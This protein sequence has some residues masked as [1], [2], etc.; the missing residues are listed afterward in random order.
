MRKR[1][2][3]K[4]RNNLLLNVLL[5]VFAAMFVFALVK[6]ILILKDYRE[7]ENIYNNIRGSYTAEEESIVHT[8]VER[9]KKTET[10]Q[11]PVVTDRESGSGQ[12]SAGSSDPGTEQKSEQNN[13]Q[14]DEADYTAYEH[15]QQIRILHT[16]FDY[17]ITPVIRFNLDAL[18]AVNPEVCGWIQIDGTHVDYPIVQGQDNSKYL[19]IAANGESNNAGSIFADYRIP[20]LYDAKNL[21]IY[22][23]NQRNSQMFHDLLFYQEDGYIDEHPYI[24]IT[25]TDGNVYQY[26]IYSA[27]Y[28]TDTYTYKY[29]FSN[30]EVYRRYLEYTRES[31]IFDL[32]VTPTTDQRII[33]L[34][35]CTNESDDRR[36]VV[37]AVLASVRKGR[38]QQ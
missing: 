25:G 8:A 13:T 18:K 5:I 17:I 15:E 24:R 1:G 11:D 26:R 28:M 30:D 16:T 21:I 20:D 38:A 22:G 31:S 4:K 27:Y 37:H 33:T 19:R 3:K 9:T 7:G 12:E 6:L 32:G 14:Q 23:H 10:L 34:S 36:F 2:M 35:T 29:A